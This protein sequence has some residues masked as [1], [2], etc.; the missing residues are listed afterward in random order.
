[1]VAHIFTRPP[2]RARTASPLLAFIAGEFA[3]PIASVWPAPHGEFF[4]LPA[5]RRH[6]VAIVLAGLARRA[7]AAGELRRTVEF[8]RDAVVAE[9]L[10]GELAQGLMRALA[11][12]GECLW[13]RE[14]YRV[15]LDLLADPMANEVLRHLDEVRPAAFAPIAALRRSTRV[16][17]PCACRRRE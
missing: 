4:A 13:Q 3:D 2:Q 17:G 5:A 16:A 15:F 7:L 14:D 1:M 6:A 11:K 12:G 8:A 10:A 9:V